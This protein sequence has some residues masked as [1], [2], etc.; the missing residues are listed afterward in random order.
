MFNIFKKKKKK[1]EFVFPKLTGYVKTKAIALVSNYAL[2]KGKIY[3]V[4]Y[5]T[6]SD[7]ILRGIKFIRDD[8]HHDS[9][10]SWRFKLISEHRENLLKIILN[11]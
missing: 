6:Y 7:N 10:H 9:S 4:E 11:D 8:G 5:Y 2:T 1:E 3:N